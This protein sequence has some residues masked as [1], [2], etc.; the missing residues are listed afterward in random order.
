MKR[1]SSWKLNVMG[2]EGFLVPQSLTQKGIQRH[3]V[4]AQ[5]AVAMAMK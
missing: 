5:P 2:I 4:L 1:T 3:S